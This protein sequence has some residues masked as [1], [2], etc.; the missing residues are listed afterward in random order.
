[1][2]D[3]EPLSERMASAVLAS[4]LGLTP[5]E[6]EAR[7]AGDGYSLYLAA[8]DAIEQ[9]DPDTRVVFDVI[10]DVPDE[11]GLVEGADQIA[12]AYARSDAWQAAHRL[13]VDAWPDE[14]RVDFMGAQPVDLA[15]LALGLTGGGTVVVDAPFDPDAV[16][17]GDHGFDPARYPLPVDIP[18][19][20]GGG[21]VGSPS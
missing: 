11:P 17:G 7:W 2:P 10:E 9:W 19:D 6:I 1:M 14:Q 20:T 8:I 15:A 21:S 18:R 16:P 12:R 13:G 5:S 3:T 4:W